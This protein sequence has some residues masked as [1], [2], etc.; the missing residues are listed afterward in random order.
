MYV[1]YVWKKDKREK[2]KQTTINAI[3]VILNNVEYLSGYRVVYEQNEMIRFSGF[4]WQMF[5]HWSRNWNIFSNFI[6]KCNF[7]WR[8]IQIFAYIIWGC[9]LL[10]YYFPSICCLLSLLCGDDI[11]FNSIASFRILLF[12]C[13]CVSSWITTKN[14]M[15]VNNVMPFLCHRRR[16]SLV[17]VFIIF[18]FH[19][20]VTFLLFSRLHDSIKLFSLP[21]HRLLDCVVNI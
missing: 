9:S 17:F 5:V 2:S 16:L 15:M 8:Y 18:F 3:F 1:K 10:F 13:V 11:S 7:C 21:S 19:Q 4:N 14:K 20:K 6:C 12:E